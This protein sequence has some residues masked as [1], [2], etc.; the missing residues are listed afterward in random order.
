MIQQ[1]YDNTELAVDEQYLNTSK[2]IALTMKKP[3]GC[4]DYEPSDTGAW[5]L[6][7]VEARTPN[8][9]GTDTKESV[10]Q[11]VYTRLDFNKGKPNPW[12]SPDITGM[13]S[14]P[15]GQLE[16]NMKNKYPSQ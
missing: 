6:A 12:T 14:D 11:C 8:H 13:P 15:L 9:Y 5:K 1:V 16:V 4:A 10:H 2:I 7:G 3:W